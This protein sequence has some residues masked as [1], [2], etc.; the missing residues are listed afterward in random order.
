VSFDPFA[1]DVIADPYPHYRVLLDGA[2][3]HHSQARDLWVLSRYEH[4]RS[5]ARA[6]DRLSSAEGIAYARFA[7]PMMITLDPPDHTR[8]RRVVSRDFT[9]RAIESWRGMVE[10]IVEGLVDDALA[11]RHVDLATLAC[12]PLPIMAIA[13]V[14][15]I[16]SE[17][18]AEFKQW[19]DGVVEGFKLADEANLN[20]E[21]TERILASIRSL[22]A[23]FH[24]L[25]EAR[26]QQP[27]DDL[28]STLMTPKDGE[29]LSADELFWFCFLLLVA[30]N[31]TTTNL[32]GNLLLALLSE[33]SQLA[34]LRQRPELIPSAVEEGLRYDPPL[35]GFFRTA[36]APYRVA[37][38]DIPEGERVL[39]LFAAA[40]RDPRQW[41]EPD[42]FDVTRQPG[43]HLA[44]GSGI[45]F[46]LGAPL[47]RLEVASFLRHLLDRTRSI[48]LAGDVVRTRNPTIRGVEQLPVELIPA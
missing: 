22:H 5:A 8:L 36:T 17:D 15:G 25:F 27:R 35:Q 13:S 10:R 42:R 9:P 47:A 41:T 29:A 45:H 34:Q 24:A 1:P 2:E 39:L 16:P 11:R 12:A 14:M 18:H 6:H 7:L 46:C 3:P 43:D 32:L 40:N 48:E 44:F 4:V 28:V 23:Y 21:S 19:S 31:E 30:G 26:R 20:A 37:S 38:T 33:P